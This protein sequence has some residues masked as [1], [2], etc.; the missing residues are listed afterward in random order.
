MWS[1]AP[2]K[3]RAPHKMRAQRATATARLLQRS[4]DDRRGQLSSTARTALAPSRL[5]SEFVNFDRQ[6]MRIGRPCH[7]RRAARLFTLLLGTGSRDEDEA[8]DGM[9]MVT[10][11]Q[12]LKDVFFEL[13]GGI[14]QPQRDFN[15]G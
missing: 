7:E 2:V 4:L 15:D 13:T 1:N 6:P 9:T 12:C 5:A 8:T 14:G 10:C 3:Q 11:D